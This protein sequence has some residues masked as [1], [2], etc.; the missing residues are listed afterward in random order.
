MQICEYLIYNY[1]VFFQ[2]IQ[3]VFDHLFFNYMII[4]GEFL[5]A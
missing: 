3:Q 5:E 1:Y 2:Y 4:L